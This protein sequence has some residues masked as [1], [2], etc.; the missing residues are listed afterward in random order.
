MAELPTQFYREGFL[1]AKTPRLRVSKDS[2]RDVRE[3]R[4][5]KVRPVNLVYTTDYVLHERSGEMAEVR[6]LG[7]RNAIC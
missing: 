6:P 7:N 3:T 4:N 1:K 5:V 2:L